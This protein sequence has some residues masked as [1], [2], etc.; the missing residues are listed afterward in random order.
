MTIVTVHGEARREV[1]PEQAVFSVTVSARDRDKPSVVTRLT[2]RSAEVGKIL[3]RYGTA[4]ERR[5]TAGLHVYQ[6]YRRRGERS[7]FHS[8]S[9]TTTV[10]VVDFDPLGELL[11]Q[12]ASSE[13]ISVSGPW[14]RLRPGSRA[15]A[16]VRR[17]A[18]TDAL[19]RAR[20][21]AAA[22]GSELDRIVEISD[23]EA[24]GAHPMMMRA[25]GGAAEDAEDGPAFDLD[26][27]QQVV[28][29]RVLMR[30]TITEPTVLRA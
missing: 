17:D 4:I 26:P 24:A 15:G 7:A 29:A 3:D 23:A 10:T 1:P 11:A 14:W 6:E 25:A 21:Y 28:E 5:E 20:E 8:G 12:L 13:S 30:V 27:R 19:D 22:V 16:D 2:E 18:V 9:L